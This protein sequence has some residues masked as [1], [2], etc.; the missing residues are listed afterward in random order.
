MT[1]LTANHG[2]MGLSRK[3]SANRPD[4]NRPAGSLFANLFQVYLNASKGI[5]DVIESMTELY[6]DPDADSEERA[7]ALD[8]LLEVL[9][10][11]TDGEALGI[12]VAEVS[13]GSAEESREIAESM[14]HQNAYFADAV[15]KHMKRLKITQSAIARKIGIK[16]SA[17]SMILSRKCR[18]QRETVKKFAR[19]LGVEPEQVWPF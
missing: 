6:T 5:K 17:V 14:S 9:F 11:P 12:D 16:Q 10:P 1:I 2:T 15:R 7:A 19:A 4:I 13:D 3:L 8:T 18:P